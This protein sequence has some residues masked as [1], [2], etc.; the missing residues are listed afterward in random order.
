LI[1]TVANGVSTL[2][3]NDLKGVIPVIA[4]NGAQ[5]VTFT[6]PTLPAAQV[7]MVIVT[8]QSQNTAGGDLFTAQ[9]ERPTCAACAGYSVKCT[10]N[11][12]NCT[13]YIPFCDLPSDYA[14]GNWQILVKNQGA[15]NGFYVAIYAVPNNIGNINLPT[16]ALSSFNI[17]VTFLV[18]FLFFFALYVNFFIIM[19]LV[20][21]LCIFHLSHVLA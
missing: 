5:P 18:Y 16:N 3:F 19:G 12:R 17:Q 1:N 14:T 20:L 9:L 7:P 13:I 10:N 8:V 6:I 21:F 11:G 15:T 4:Q 2:V